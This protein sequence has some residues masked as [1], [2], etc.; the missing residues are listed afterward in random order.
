MRLAREGRK[1]SLMHQLGISC[2]A[3]ANDC[4]SLIIVSQNISDNAQ[5]RYRDTWKADVTF[6]TLPSSLDIK[7]RL[8]EQPS[9]EKTS[10]KL[11]HPQISSILFPSFAIVSILSLPVPRSA[12]Y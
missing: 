3:H 5:M 10:L 6:W 2:T 4:R 12:N 7:H 1:E 9:L 11:I 8:H